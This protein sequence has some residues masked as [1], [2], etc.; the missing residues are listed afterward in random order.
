MQHAEKKSYKLSC[1]A[2]TLNSRLHDVTSI[3][4]YVDKSTLLLIREVAH[5]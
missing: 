3:E 2:I 5:M 1:L 4:N